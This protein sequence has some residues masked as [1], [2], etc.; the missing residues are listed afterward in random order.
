MQQESSKDESNGET[1]IKVKKLRAEFFYWVVRNHLRELKVQLDR[2]IM[3]QEIREVSRSVSYVET[4]S[5]ENLTG[6]TLIREL[7]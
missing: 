7:E 4:R 3:E 1:A 6:T 2:Q 5:K